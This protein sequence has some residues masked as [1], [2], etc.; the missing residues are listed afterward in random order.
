[1]GLAKHSVYY[2]AGRVATASVSGF[3]LYTFTHLLSPIEYGR[4]SLILA[5]SGLV[6]CVVFEWLR[7]CLIR[8]C[9]GR[10]EKSSQ[11]LGTIGLSFFGL[12]ILL[13]FISAV[14]F[15]VGFETIE[16]NRDLIALIGILAC[17]Q[18]WFELA[19]DACRVELSPI[20]YGLM[21]FNRAVLTLLF[22]A[23]L[24]IH[25][26]SLSAVILG[27]VLG[28]LVAS[29][30][31]PQWLLGLTGICHT[32]FRQL[33]E[34]IRY[35][36][37]ISF[38]LGFT[39]ILNSADLFMLA[40]IN[41]PEQAGVYSSAYNLAQYSIG[42]LLAGLGLAVLPHATRSYSEMNLDAT[43]KLLGQNLIILAAIAVPATVGLGLVSHKLDKF[44]LGNFDSTQ[45]AIVTT[46]VALGIM[47]AAIRSYALD[48]VFMITQKTRIQAY[49]LGCSAA[50]NVSLN[51]CLIPKWGSVG[52][53]ISTSL[54]FSLA[55]F[56]SAFIG[57][58]YIRI[59]IYW[60]DLAKIIFS[61]FVMWLIVLATDNGQ[62]SLAALF[63]QVLLG[64]V[65]YGT[66]MPLM[67]LGW[68]RPGAFR[69]E[70]YW[71]NL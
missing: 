22:G 71:R 40:V 19:L 6:S 30:F 34:F 48:I 14:L 67:Y 47:V 46:I 7:Q 41:G 20:R 70:S 4:Y 49:I 8:F 65:I 15:V 53:A 50:F 21:A 25:T 2:L 28:N 60:A 10:A 16:L 63:F 43:S 11:L 37:P 31:A 55:L 39:V 68:S 29:M 32:R 36:L 45:S 35:G 5:S 69:F 62:M 58:R 26:G 9:T 13:L 12:T 17:A 57:R 27:V 3:A 24:A 33:G 1:M 52:A 59:Q 61:T 18:S 23:S 38:T 51:M 56:L 54:S 42:S 66:V 44:L 64:V